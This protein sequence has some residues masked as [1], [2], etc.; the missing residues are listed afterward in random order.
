MFEQVKLD[1]AANALE[2]WIDQL[3]I[4]THYGKHH[5]TYTKNFNDLVENQ[6]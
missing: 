2:P 3:T 5:V 4:E 6:A 1:Y